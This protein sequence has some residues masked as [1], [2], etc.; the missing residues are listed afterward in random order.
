MDATQ[1][2][3]L[4]KL[5]LAHAQDDLETAELDLS[6]GKY[7]GAVNRAYYAMF[8]CVRAALL[9]HNIQRT[10]HSG[11]EAT[12]GQILIKPQIIEPE[13]FD[14]YRMARE[15]RESQDYER[16]AQEITEGEAQ[17]ILAKT[18]RFVERLEKYL[19]EVGA[20]DQPQSL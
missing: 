5:D 12:F 20:L 15:T 13:Y 14:M 6:A 7:R 11:V 2:S 19:R 16:N 1:K 10:K 18:K 9:W 17:Q 4:I 8:H 3:E